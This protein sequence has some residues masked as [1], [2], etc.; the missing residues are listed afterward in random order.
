MQDCW[1]GLLNSLILQVDEYYT[2]N[3]KPP[4]QYCEEAPPIKCHGTVVAST[5]SECLA[6]RS[7]DTLQQLIIFFV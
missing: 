2:G 6:F 7:F 1:A 5:G 3:T 4:M